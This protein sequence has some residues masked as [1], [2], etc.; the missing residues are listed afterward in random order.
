MVNGTL[1]VP[2]SIKEHVAVSNHTYIGVDNATCSIVT[3]SSSLMYL[4]SLH[5][6]ILNLVGGMCTLRTYSIC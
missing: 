5:A 6:D 3:F 2:S 1:R 4:R